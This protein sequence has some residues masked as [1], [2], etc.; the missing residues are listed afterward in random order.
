VTLRGVSRRS[1]LIA[2]AL[3]GAACGAPP[4]PDTADAHATAVPSSSPPSTA[5]VAPPSGEHE[6]GV[7]VEPVA[8]ALTASEPS[9]PPVAHFEALPVVGHLDAVVALP[10]ATGRQPV[11]FATHGAG[12]APEHHCAA[13]RHQLGERGIVVCPRGAMVNRLVGPDAG[14]YYP[15]HFALEKEVLATVESFEAA[16]PGRFQPESYVYAGYSQGATMGA[17]MLPGHAGRFK[18]V[19]LIEGGFDAWALSSARQFARSGGERVAFVCGVAGCQ[20]GAEKSTQLLARADL[21]T[22]SRYAPGAGHTYLGAVA[23]RIQEAF[24]WLVD[25]YPG[26]Q[27]AAPPG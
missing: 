7:A 19:L 11:L 23:D 8:P 21:L 12:G 9:E 20:R 10:A 17:L 26:W 24:H 2:S 3:L 5:S 1:A 16:Y 13:W 15:N 6:T 22:L 25:G 18:R 27:P 14:F 4:A